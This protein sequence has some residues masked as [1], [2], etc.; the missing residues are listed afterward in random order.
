MATIR[1]A[2]LLLS[3]L[4]LTGCASKPPVMWR[5][6]DIETQAASSIRLVHQGKTLGQVNREQVQLVNAV[7]ARIERVVP[8]TQA[9]LYI[10]TESS[11]NAFA[12]ADAG[13]NGRPMIGITLGMLDLLGADK[14]AYAAIIG[15]EFAHLA[16]H[17]G[18]ARQQRHNVG[19]VASTALGVL[20][21]VAGVPMGGTVADLGVTAIERTYSRE[22]EARADEIGFGY[23]IAAGFDPAGAVR[24]W[25][26]MQAS[27][28]RA[29]GFSIPFLATHPVTDER[30]E[31]MRR[32]SAGH[33]GEA[34]PTTSPAK[35]IERDGAAA[36]PVR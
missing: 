14:D 15:H 23:L 7:K 3:A 20:L 21:S 31:A 34:V 28:A 10:Q 36:V 4:L 26:K 11:P 32:L 33:G 18:A 1:L 27:S 8:G 24:L 22:E 30:I 6:A 12:S 5:A 2:A 9:D 29:S 16:L 25:Q 35:R 17:H 13:N 19:W